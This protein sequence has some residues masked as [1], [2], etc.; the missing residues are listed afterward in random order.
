MK[1][2][3]NYY[4]QLNIENLHYISDTYYFNYLNQNYKLILYNRNFDYIPALVKINQE[5]LKKITYFHEIILTKDNQ[6]FIIVDNK[7]Y[8]LLKLSN[9]IN[10]RLSFYDIFQNKEDILPDTKIL[11][12]FDWAN[13]WISKNDYLEEILIHSENKYYEQLPIFY[14]YMG[15]CENAISYFQNT[16]TNK[17]ETELDYFTIC[18]NRINVIDSVSDLYNPLSIIYDHRSRDIA[19]YL[20]N[21]FILNEYDYREI[22]E[23][24]NSLDFSDFGFSML[25]ARILYPTFFFDTCDLL[26]N[27]KI[28]IN[29]L[30]KI[31]ERINE[32]RLF[33]KE[34]YY[35]IR[36]KA[37]IDEVNWITKK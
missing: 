11:L 8:I 34:I 29:E 30:D 28:D 1:N 7:C 9:V 10:D 19:E 25:F 5:K 36:R 33:L 18:H 13:L 3:I 6:P 20:K 12:K 26:M 17:H 37:N 21:S 35:I 27:G 16:I 4:Y 31:G 32:Y 14:F 15:L 22:E 2:T 23:Y 24:I